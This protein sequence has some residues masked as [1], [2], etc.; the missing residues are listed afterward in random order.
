MYIVKRYPDGI[1]CWVDLST[2]DTEA[3]KKFYGGLFGW[4]F[5]DEPTGMGTVYTMC[6]IEGKNVAGLGPM[7]EEMQAQGAPPF[8]TSYVKH[9]NV[10]AVAARVT[11]AGGNVMM[12]PMDVM[13][14]GRMFL[15]SDP[16]GAVFGVWQPK[17][18]IGAQIVNSLNTLFWNELQT[19]DVE[20]AKSFYSTVFGWGHDEDENGYV[21][22]KTDERVHSGMIQIDDTWGPVP[23]NWA[24][25]FLVEDVNASTEKVI[26]LGGNVLVPLRE[27]GAMGSFSVVQDPQGGAFTIMQS[28]V[29][30]IPLGVE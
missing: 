4:Q 7:P 2:T 5:V 1:F 17:S 23:P 14:T 22:F 29:V 20:A 21:A 12:P 16:T 3:A 6:Q 18:H 13:E 24:V 30:D 19:R 27:V 15:A 8:W 9:D 10:D 25:Y 26:E 28:S 11:E